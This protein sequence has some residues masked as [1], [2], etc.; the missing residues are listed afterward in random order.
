MRKIL[1]TIWIVLHGLTIWAQDF[2]TATSAVS[3]MRV[4]WNLGNTLDSNSGNVNNMWIEAWSQRTPEDYEKAWGQPVTKPE[5]L[6]MMKEAGFN[7]IRVPVTW[8]PHMEAT[9]KSVKWDNA[10]QA[11][12]TWDKAND[13]IGTKIQLAWMKR[14]H[15]VVDYVISQGMYCI[16]NVHHD[17]GDGNTAW[18]VASEKD[19]NAQ[20]ER[21]EAVWKQIAEEFKDYDEHLLFEGY[22]EM[23]DP[24][25][26]WN[27]ASY[28]T[29]SKYDAT[30]AASAYNAINSYA[31]SFVNAV[32]STGGNNALRNLIV[33]TY[34]SCCGS[35]TWN[36]HLKDPLT[37]MKLPIDNVSNHIIF[38]VHTYL[39]VKNLNTAKSVVNQTIRDIK[40]NLVSKGAPVIFGEWGTTTEN[41][42]ENY[43]SNM[44]A[45]ARYF[46][47]QAKTNNMGTFYWM[48]LSD[49]EHR[50]VPEFNQSDLKDAIIKGYYGDGGYSAIM[51]TQKTESTVVTGYFNLEGH[52]LPASRRG[53]NI[54]RMSNGVVRTLSIR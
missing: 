49:G 47:E 24:Y 46:V 15:E 16:L 3:N 50:T 29:S 21:F 45:F 51:S 39:D 9:F 4:G 38:E 13:D 14:V 33:N 31:Q 30:V 23:L 5:L 42:Y 7:A 32:R 35:G 25:G 11:L 53:L 6:K 52:R 34:G 19:Y 12:T 22:N 27:F 44:L 41:G 26:S 37:Y 28:N 1:L 18:V 54:V 40:S 48:G 20:K 17:T 36:A 10:K 43:R 2:E 8:Y